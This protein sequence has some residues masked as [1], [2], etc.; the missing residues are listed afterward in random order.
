MP[1]E[2]GIRMREMLTTNPVFAGAI[3][4]MISGAIMYLLRSIPKTLW[5]LR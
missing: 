3:G 2:G 1:P 4:L 5:D